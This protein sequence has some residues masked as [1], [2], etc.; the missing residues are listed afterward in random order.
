MVCWSDEQTEMWLNV[1]VQNSQEEWKQITQLEESEMAN[2]YKKQ[3]IDSI[4]I[5]ILLIQ[6][7]SV[8]WKIN[9][10]HIENKAK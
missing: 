5:A 10:N 6:H 4:Y 3:K 9:F 8:I 7:I 1:L 2:F